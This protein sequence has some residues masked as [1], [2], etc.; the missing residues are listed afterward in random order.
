MATKD[1]NR[2]KL[3][4]T[5]SSYSYNATNNTR[6]EKAIK[7]KMINQKSHNYLWLTLTREK[8]DLSYYTQNIIL[9]LYMHMRIPANA[10]DICS[11]LHAA[12]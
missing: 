9:S 1:H 12:R 8:I 3:A 11:L 10:C 2:G 4:T 5:V 6:G 7:R